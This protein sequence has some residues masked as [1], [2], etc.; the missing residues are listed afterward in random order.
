MA[1]RDDLFDYLPVPDERMALRI[2][3]Q[4]AGVGALCGG[5]EA[6]EVARRS[7]FESALPDRLELI[8]ATA[9]SWML[10][11]WT[12]GLAGGLWAQLRMRGVER[13]RRYRL[14]F[15]VGALAS[16]LTVIAPSVIRVVGFGDVST[17][18][19]FLV[20]VVFVSGTAWANAGYWY[21]RELLGAAP[22]LP[23]W[24]ISSL[25]TVALGAFALLDSRPEP[26][27]RTRLSGDPS[28]VVIV[29]FSGLRRD[30]LG[31]YGGG[32]TPTL[33]ALAREGLLAEDAVAELPA[34][35]PAH[36]TLWT[37]LTTWQ[38]GVR[39]DGV[40][41]ADTHVT[42][43]EQLRALGW[44]TGAFLG[45]RTLG[46]ASGLAQ[47]FDVYDDALAPR[48]RLALRSRAGSLTMALW[49]R[50]G[51]PAAIPALLTR[52]GSDTVARALDWAAR[53]PPDAPHLLWV[54]LHEP[55]AP[56]ER[57]HADDSARGEAYRQAVAAAD[58]ALAQLL[59][60][61]EALERPHA[62]IVVVAGDHGERLQTPAGHHGLGEEVIRVPLLVRARPQAWSAGTR[63]PE[64]TGLEV[65]PNTVLRWLGAP[66]LQGGVDLGM[67]ALGTPAPE[68]PLLLEGRSPAGDHVAGVRS[69]RL[70]F[71]RDARGERLH[72]LTVDPL[73]QSDAAAGQPE[74]AAAARALLA[75]RPAAAPSTAVDPLLKGLVDHP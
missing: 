57:P 44:R 16:V 1:P 14:G 26:E 48:G 33:D 17:S 29:T 45:A 15:V 72:D 40:P 61:L 8:A 2:A 64:Q 73:E 10:L 71:L 28:D 34:T 53:T 32:G 47:G 24:A 74:A 4:V 31:A 49:A 43:A 13:W 36:A 7:T 11:A 12:L 55:H 59:T 69:N 42:L 18:L 20:L 54:H 5:V 67:R 58:S 75:G 35:A 65:V 21:R 50:F 70:K 63:L 68:A 52:P 23:W 51:N 25:G 37:G 9:L 62:S 22:R 6:L 66:A 39:A 41:L 60:G 19:A 3:G 56:L 30:A 27:R 38:H 46:R